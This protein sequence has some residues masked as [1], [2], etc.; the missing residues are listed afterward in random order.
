MKKVICRADGNAK[1]GLGHLYRMFA[2]YE[3]YK[4]IF[5]IVFLTRSDSTIT[6]IPESYNIKLIP[7]SIDIT[8]EPEWIATHFLS[9]KTALI[10]DGYQFISSYQKTE[11]MSVR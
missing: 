2:L 5:D 6:V 9:K 3:I 4:D 7:E 11:R 8:S 1:T 10:A